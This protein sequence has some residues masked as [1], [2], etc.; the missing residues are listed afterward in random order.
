MRLTRFVGSCSQDEAVETG[1]GG[2]YIIEARRIGRGLQRFCELLD[3]GER[4]SKLTG[5]IETY[6]RQITKLEA[7]VWAAAR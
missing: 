6:A 4:P 1:N 3:Q 2:M 7:M 5:L